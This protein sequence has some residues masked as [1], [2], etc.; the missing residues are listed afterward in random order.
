M[1]KVKLVDNVYKELIKEINTKVSF[2]LIPKTIKVVQ[3]EFIKSI[4]NNDYFTDGEK[5]A[6][7]LYFESYA[8]FHSKN[9]MLFESQDRKSTRLN[10]SH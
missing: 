5:Q 2:S 7:S 8:T 9:M 3:E 1:S 6:L 4:P 10:S